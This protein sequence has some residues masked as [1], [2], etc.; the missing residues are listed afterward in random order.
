MHGRRVGI[1]A[2]LWRKWVLSLS[3]FLNNQNGSVVDAIAMWKRNVDKSFAG[4]EE[5]T[6]CFAVVH[7]TNYQLPRAKCRTCK[8]LFH[9]DCLFKWFASSGQSTC[10]LCRALF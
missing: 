3:V 5:C 6:V 7:G 4:V 1:N 10:P 9:S 2:Q 8:H